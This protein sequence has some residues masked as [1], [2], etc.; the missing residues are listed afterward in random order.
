[1]DLS[2]CTAGARGRE[3]NRTKHPGI[4]TKH[5]SRL[6]FCDL[7]DLSKWIRSISRQFQAISSGL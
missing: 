2:L 7:C 1:M 3:G 5:R 6:P 4:L